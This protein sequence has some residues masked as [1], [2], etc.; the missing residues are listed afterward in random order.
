MSEQNPYE[1]LGVTENSS[2]EEIQA[3]KK[4]LFE[5]YGHDSAVLETVEIAYDS[6]IMDRLRLRQEGKIKVPEKIR[7]PDRSVEKSLKVPQIVK[8]DSAVWLQELID[9]PSQADILWPT[10]IFLTLSA[11]AVFTQNEA[12]NAVQNTN[13]SILPLLM[14][15]GFI[16]NIYFLNR[17]EGRSGRAFLISF[18]ALFAG[19]AL[20][21]GLANLLLGQGGTA[22]GADQFASA[23]TFCLFW[24]V[25]CFLR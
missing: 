9:T 14:A 23:V 13:P 22:L 10:G 7:F 3:A 18:V 5:Q 4:R 16:A 21:T 11:I 17:K 12:Q 8:E 15:L 20:G 24:L 25:S 6:I 1:Q 2:F 19:I